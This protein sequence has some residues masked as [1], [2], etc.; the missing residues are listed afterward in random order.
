MTP[1]T[2]TD[3]PH[4]TPW[5]DPESGVESFI[6]TERVAPLQ[7]SF[8]FTNPSVSPDERWLWFYTAFPPA[9]YKCL[10]VVSLDPARPLIRHFPA[11]AFTTVSPMVAPEGD[12]VYF[13]SGNAV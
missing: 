3:H 13:C 7:Q 9:P 11:A 8:Y 1:A 10:A 2:L 5:T 6:L 4:F 12:A